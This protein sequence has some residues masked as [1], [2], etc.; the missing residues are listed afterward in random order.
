MKVP[1]KVVNKAIIIRGRV[2]SDACRANIAVVNI[3]FL[4]FGSLEKHK[5]GT[6]K[7]DLP[8]GF[9]ERRWPR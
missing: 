4:I 1:A 3:L 6:L 9:G 2:T 8:R 5:K 7:P